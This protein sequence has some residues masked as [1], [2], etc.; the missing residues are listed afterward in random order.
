M[1]TCIVW[2]VLGA[3]RG[4]HVLGEDGHFGDLMVKIKEISTEHVLTVIF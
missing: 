3:V 1:G 4:S 2:S